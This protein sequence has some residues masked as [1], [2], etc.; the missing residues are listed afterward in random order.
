M[1]GTWKMKSKKTSTVEL[2]ARTLAYGYTLGFWEGQEDNAYAV[3]ANRE[4]NIS[5]ATRQAHDPKAF[6]AFLDPA[7]RLNRSSSSKWLRANKWNWL[8]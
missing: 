5:K 7:R 2:L 1:A 4:K 6:R 3:E 8:K